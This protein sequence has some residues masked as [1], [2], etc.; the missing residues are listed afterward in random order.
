MKKG[1]TFWIEDWAIT[2]RKKEFVKAH[3]IFWILVTVLCTAV[4][5][6]EDSSE[7]MMGE[8]DSGEPESD[9]IWDLPPGFPVPSVPEDN[10]M[11]EE[12]VELGR[13][14]FYD[15]RLSGNQ[16]FSC[17][18]CHKQEFAFTDGL[19]KA[20]GST[21]EIHP[22][23]SM[24]LTNV[25]YNST[26]G[27]ANPLLTSLEDQAM[28]PMFGEEP[29]ELGLAGLE[30][31]LLERLRDDVTYQEMF[32]EAFPRDDDPFTV[33]NITKALST[34]QRTMISGNSPWDQHLSGVDGV[35][36]RDALQGALLFLDSEET[37]CFHC[38][39]DFN[40]ADSSTHQG[41]VFAERAFHNTGLYNLD[42]DG[43]YPALGGEGLYELTKAPED[44]G[45]FKAPTLRNIAVTGPYMHDGSVETLEEVME[46]YAVGGR[47][48]EEGELAGVGNESPLRSQFVNGFAISPEQQQNILLFLRSLTDEEFLTDPRF[49]NPFE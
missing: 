9:W 8:P 37:E 47:T 44:M 49:S 34:F 12:K 16:T 1:R 18:S 40:F 32:P 25:A 33:K 20:E 39:G 13:R 19:G 26:F 43:K 29:V 5:C 15:E 46:H 21:G 41:K 17:A 24:S 48:I 2:L 30:N 38:H 11:S 35:M 27:W 28:L 42:G 4:A 23:S 6:G 36:S 45:R 22:R 7:M 31:E 10:L 14:L 3:S